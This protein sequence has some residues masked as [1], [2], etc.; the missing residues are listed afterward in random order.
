MKFLG[1]HFVFPVVIHKTD[2]LYGG[3][4]NLTVRWDKAGYAGSMKITTYT[5]EIC[6]KT[7]KWQYAFVWRPDVTRWHWRRRKT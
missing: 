7:K 6:T 3:K 2:T 4:P 1:I 5:L